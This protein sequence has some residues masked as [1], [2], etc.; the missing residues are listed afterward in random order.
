[1]S[2]P[3]LI[4]QGLQIYYE[5][6]VRMNIPLDLKY[7][8]EHEWV[9]VDGG[10]AVA[11]ITDYA[12]KELGDIVYIDLPQV[13]RSVKVMEP[14]GVIESLK[15]VSDL[16]SPVT[17]SIFKVNQNLEETPELVNASPYDK[18]WII[19]VNMTSMSE[20]D[21]M[22]TPKEYEKYVKYLEG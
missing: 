13:G 6:Q 7:T 17:G 3:D 15:T 19:L 4:G 9:R 8:K 16:Y 22:M 12:Q 18:G 14:F 11:G 1:M 21:G 5:R 20:I 10:K 2:I